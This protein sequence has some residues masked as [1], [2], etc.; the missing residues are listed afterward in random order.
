MLRNVP[1]PWGPMKKLFDLSETPGEG[2]GHQ[3][4]P[5]RDLG[6]SKKLEKVLGHIET[7]GRPQFVTVGRALVPLKPCQGFS[8]Q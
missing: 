8:F 3:R 6:P 4:D 5:Q 1:K 7:Q 2:L